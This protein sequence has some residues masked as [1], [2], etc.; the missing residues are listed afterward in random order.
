MG[1]AKCLF[2]SEFKKN[3]SAE[4]LMHKDERHYRNVSVPWCC[5]ADGILSLRNNLELTDSRH[6]WGRNNMLSV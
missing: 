2:N 6:L 4:A 5:S 3:S 1:F